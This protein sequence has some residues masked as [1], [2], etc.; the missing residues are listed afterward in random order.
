MLAKRIITG[1]VGGGLTIFII[2]EGN[3]LFF[4][5]MTLLALLGWYE[6]V[7]LLAAKKANLTEY[8]RGPCQGQRPVGRGA[9]ALPVCLGAQ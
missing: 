5:M 1:I 7:R 9:Q 8:A 4:L 3:W 2:Y 6:Y